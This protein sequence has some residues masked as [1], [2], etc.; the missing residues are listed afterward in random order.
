MAWI[1]K[2]ER[3]DGTRVL[4]VAWR[5]TVTRKSESETFLAVNS[6]AAKSFLRDVEAAGETWPPDWVPGHGYPK[7]LALEERLLL[8][9]VA[10]VDDGNIRPDNSASTF[11]V[12]VRPDEALP[13]D[14]E[15]EALTWDLL[16]VFEFGDDHPHVILVSHQRHT[17]SNYRR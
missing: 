7:R 1:S 12:G 3:K 6:D 16:N 17:R 8:G 4:R 2:R 10:D 14:A 11:A 15:I 5:D 13:A 9:F